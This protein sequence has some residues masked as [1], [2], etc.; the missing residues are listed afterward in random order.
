VTDPK[1]KSEDS[2]KK[3]KAS[4]SSDDPALKP[5]EELTKEEQ[6]ERFEQDL[7]DNDWGHRPC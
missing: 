4:T 6:M 5:V 7:K 3:K 2:E 1:S